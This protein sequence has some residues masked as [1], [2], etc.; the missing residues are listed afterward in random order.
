MV[1]YVVR[2]DGKSYTASSDDELVDWA[3]SGRVAR[4]DLIHVNDGSGWRKASDLSFL[5]GSLSEPDQP[6]RD[7][8]PVVYWTQKGHQNRLIGDLQVVVA[9]IR[10]G[11]LKP[12]D[13]IFHAGTQSW[14]ELRDS[15]FLM[16][17]FESNAAA[18]SVLP[19][20]EDP[21]V[22]SIVEIPDDFLVQDEETRA[23]DNGD[24]DKNGFT[25]GPLTTEETRRIVEGVLNTE[26]FEA[27]EH[28]TSSTT[29]TALSPF[30]NERAK[31]WAERLDSLPSDSQA[32]L[33]DRHNLFPIIYD[34]ARCFLDLKNGMSLTQPYILELGSVGKSVRVDSPL[35]AYAELNNALDE[36]L[37]ERVKNVLAVL[38]E[39]ERAGFRRYVEGLLEV[40]FWINEIIK[41]TELDAS[42]TSEMN[43]MA[44]ECEPISRL[45]TAIRHLILVRK[46]RG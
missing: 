24:A 30:F 37:S 6:K 9:W 16:S 36:H 12:D 8:P 38:V 7:R 33:Q 46:R 15:A 17:I 5:M 35:D 14:F 42:D 40:M 26:E 39:K 3:R 11:S 10:D 22:E 34:V 23:Q 1:R 28:M 20:S 32:K 44:I 4:S 43:T 41:P 2:R 18:E 45:E 27:P 31:I 29:M 21:V 25:T 13:M 19:T